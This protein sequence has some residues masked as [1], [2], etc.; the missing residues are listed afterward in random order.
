MCALDL[1][2]LPV[3]KRKKGLNGIRLYM[4]FPIEDLGF[5]ATQKSNAMY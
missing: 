3:G 1:A 2:L 5:L 4:K